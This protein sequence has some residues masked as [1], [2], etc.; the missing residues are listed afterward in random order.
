MP[1]PVG[2]PRNIESPERMW[3][4]FEAY[5]LHEAEHPMSKR[6]YVGKDGNAVDT[7]LEVP[8]TFEGFECYLAD[9]DYIS[10]LGQYS[11]NRDNAYTEFVPIITRIRKNCFVHN[12]KGAAVRLFDANLISKKLGLIAKTETEHKGSLNLPNLPDIG[13]RK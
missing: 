9:N 4:L 13:D 10:D 3:E 11:A 8:I 1:N 2:R 6:E 5:V 12:F 7:K